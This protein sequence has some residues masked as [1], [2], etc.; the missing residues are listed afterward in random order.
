MKK[1]TEREILNAWLKYHGKTVE[2]VL[3][4]CP[5]AA[6]DPAWFTK[7]PVTKEQEAEWIAW[8]RGEVKRRKMYYTEYGIQMTIT[9]LGPTCA[10]DEYKCPHNVID[11]ADDGYIR[12]K[13]CKEEI[14]AIK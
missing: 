6:H 10:K 7:Y 9:H 13:S 4:E 2:D 14:R 5:E 12:C 8:L 11:R 1:L 3:K